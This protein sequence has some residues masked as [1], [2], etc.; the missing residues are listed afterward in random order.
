MNPH[1]HGKL[2]E[3]GLKRKAELGIVSFEDFLSGKCG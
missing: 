2:W 1:G 3:I